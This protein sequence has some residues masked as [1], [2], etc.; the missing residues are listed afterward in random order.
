[1]FDDLVALSGLPHGGRILEIGCGTGQATLPMAERG[2]R[3][4]AVELGANLAA[5]AR[6]KL[7]RFASVEV[8]VGNFEDW[9]LPEEGF[10]LVMAASSFHWLDTEVALSKAAAALRPEGAL[11]IISGSHVAGGDDPFFVEVQA[12][13][14]R[15]HAGHTAGIAAYRTGAYPVGVPGDR[16]I[17]LVRAAA[18]APVRVGARV[19][20]TDVS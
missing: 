5:V 4:V 16:R 20:N 8:H 13:Y 15:L 18:A 11:A 19:Y 6:H 14:K 10:D 1:M 7:A 17:G 3:V 2:Y 9:R 12:C